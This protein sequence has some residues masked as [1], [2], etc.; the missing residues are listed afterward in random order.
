MCV[1]LIDY[2]GHSWLEKQSQRLWIW[3]LAWLAGTWL[4]CMWRLL[5]AIDIFRAS[6][7]TT[8]KLKHWAKRSKCITSG[9]WTR[10][11]TEAKERQTRK[12]RKVQIAV[13]VDTSIKLRSVQNIARHAIHATTK[14][15]QRFAILY[16]IGK[17]T[18]IWKDFEDL[19]SEL[20]CLPRQHHRD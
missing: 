3:R 2:C 20:G 15:L 8:N 12:N 14:N 16:E 10:R 7:I 1:A 4:N 9:L 5:K 11:I 18:D 6:E 19:F 17:D 13:D